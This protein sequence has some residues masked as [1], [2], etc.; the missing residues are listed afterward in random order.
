M[1]RILTVS[2]TFLSSIIIAQIPSYVPTNGLKGW[3]PFCN[4]AN[5][6]TINANNGTV[7]GATLTTDRFGNANSAYFFNGSS[8]IATTYA[9]VLGANKRAVSFWAKTNN[10]SSPMTGVSWGK[11]ESFPNTGK[12]FGCEFNVFSSGLTIDGADCAITYNPPSSHADNSWHHYVYQMDSAALLN[13]VQIFMDGN[14]VS[15]VATD[16][17][18]T[19]TMNTLPNYNVWFGKMDPGLPYYF[20]GSLDDIA[21]WNRKLT[22][23]EITALYNGQSPCV[24]GTTTSSFSANSQTICVGQTVTFTNTSAFANAYTWNFG[25]GNSSSLTNP[26]HTYSVSGTYTVSLTAAGSNT[27]SSSSVIFVN[28]NPNL[29]ITSSN[30][31][32]CSGTT[33]NL[34]AS[35][36]NTYTWLPS[37]IQSPIL[38]TTPISTTVYTVLG[39]SSLGCSS[40]STYSV[41]VNPTPLV[42][43]VG[44]NTL[45][46]G[47][48]LLLMGSGGASSYTWQSI[49]INTASVSVSPSANTTYTLYGTSNLGC[50]GMA[51]FSISVFPSSNF[52]ITSSSS[53]VCI[54]QSVL[55]SANGVNSYSLI[56]FGLF[57]NTITVTPSS[58]MTYSVIGTTNMGC[59]NTQTIN[60]IA[61][62]IPTIEIN[63]DS[64]ICIGNSSILSANTNANSLIWSNSQTSSTIQITPIANAYFSAIASNGNCMVTDSIFVQVVSKINSD[65]TYEII[66]SC[67]GLVNFNCLNYSPYNYWNF[68]NGNN[69]INNCQFSTN[70][71]TTQDVTHITNPNSPCSDTTTKNITVNIPS[72]NEQ[73]PN[74]I[75]PNNDSKNDFI[76]F[77]KFI[78]CEIIEVQIFNRWGVVV[79]DLK[80]ETS[81]IWDG[82]TTSGQNVLMAFISTS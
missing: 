82:T 49:G 60:I 26:T 52:T 15:S 32:I 47:D 74:V 7:Y 29:T 31:V 72:I 43:I 39:T 24:T 70:L 71:T 80:S 28:P 68:Y 20:N 19:S 21:I 5:D 79:S 17:R 56:G 40:Q 42:L 23:T 54:G 6:L 48:N 41:M 38:N 36:A 75:T 57:S 33:V 76:N 11:S 61:V 59:I 69:V 22:Q 58:T 81:T 63:G 30:S 66:D 10:A 62:A 45:C 51:T 67:L 77:K 44:S 14:L 18:G 8:Y 50:V 9:G 25:D 55:I 2:L 35:G 12:K 34:S 37:G 65:F 73:L 16:F 4:N 78:P 3:W 1:N 13:Q 53:S 46:A 27:A 64:I